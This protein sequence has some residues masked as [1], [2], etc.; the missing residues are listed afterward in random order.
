[1]SRRHAEVILT[2]DGRY[3]LTDC[4]SAGGAYIHESAGW[5]QLRQ[6]FV[7]AGARLRFGDF[8]I[9]AARFE[10]LRACGGAPISGPAR[11]GGSTPAE[12]T[13]PQ[14]EP[15]PDPRRGLRRDTITGEIIEQR[16]GEHG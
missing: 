10:A 12:V 14:P 9:I 13:A 15:G 3:Y 7:S 6:E 8:E 1:M 5:R 11:G 4:N 2:P 16:G